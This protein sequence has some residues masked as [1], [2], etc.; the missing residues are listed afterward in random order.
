MKKI[1]YYDVETT[2]LDKNK[3]DIVQLAYLIEVDGEVKLEKSYYVKPMH[4]ENI[5]PK[6]LEIIGRTKEAIMLEGI[7]PRDVYIE[8]VADLGKFC[9]KF[10]STDKFYPAG[11]NVGFDLDFLNEFFQRNNDPY[12]GSWIN[13]KIL[14]PLAI[15]RLMDYKGDISLPNYKLSTVCRHLGINLKAHDALSD[16][17]ATRE[18]VQ[19]ILNLIKLNN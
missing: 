13:Y 5:D 19:H 16:I 7:K 3:N 2:G 17:K 9:N 11:Y 18:V 8:F 1:L 15:F 6:A 14:D 4:P 10:D 12:L